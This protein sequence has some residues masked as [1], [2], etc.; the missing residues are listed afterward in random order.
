MVAMK[1]DCSGRMNK[2]SYLTTDK[3]QR[4]GFTVYEESSTAAQISRCNIELK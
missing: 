2:L 4:E 3:K 1:L